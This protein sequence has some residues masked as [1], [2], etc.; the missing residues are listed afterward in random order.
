M[1]LGIEQ[2][3]KDAIDLSAPCPYCGHHQQLVTA[4]RGKKIRLSGSHSNEC[5]LR[6]TC[7]TQVDNS[8]RG[9]KILGAQWDYFT[10]NTLN[11]SS[12]C[13]KLSEQIHELQTILNRYKREHS[14]LTKQ[15]DILQSTKRKGYDE[16]VKENEVLRASVNNLSSERSKWLR[17]LKR[18]GIIV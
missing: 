3:I 18:A 4:R 9:V 13:E 8:L 15:L 6:N 7:T 1:S 14:G 10:M 5:T 2:E 11:Q 12:E 16:M 17:K